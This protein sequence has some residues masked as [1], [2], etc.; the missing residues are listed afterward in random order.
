MVANSDT[1]PDV[2]HV[3]ALC[4]NTIGSY[5]CTCEEGYE[6]NGFACSWRTTTTKAT[7]TTQMPT[8]KQRRTEGK[9]LEASLGVVMK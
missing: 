3:N 8:T 2:C 4:T 5:K 6:G 9:N 7:T 1:E